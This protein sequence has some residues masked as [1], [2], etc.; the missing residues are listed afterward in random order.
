MEITVLT[1]ESSN[2]TNTLTNIVQDA[3]VYPPDQSI[4]KDQKLK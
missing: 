3:N 2:A 1:S 4:K